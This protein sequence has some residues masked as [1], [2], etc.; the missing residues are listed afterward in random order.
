MAN[1]LSLLFTFLFFFASAHGRSLQMT[2][3][4]H[5]KLDLQ[6]DFFSDD[7]NAIKGVSLASNPNYTGK[8][9]YND[10]LGLVVIINQYPL[11][12][13]DNLDPCITP[14]WSWIL[15]TSDAR[16]RIIALELSSRDLVAP[17]PDFSIMDALQ[18][19]DLSL[20]IFS[21]PIPS[22]LGTF[23]DLQELNLEYNYFTGQVP[24]S[25]LC[26][27]NLKLSLRGN[28]A[29]DTTD[30]C[31]GSNYTPNPPTASNRNSNSNNRSVSRKKSSTPAIV[32]SIVGVFGFIGICV[33]IFAI[34]NHKARAAAAIAEAS[35]PGTDVAKG[36]TPLEEMPMNTR[37]NNMSPI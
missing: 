20:N 21:G 23:P 14:R 28:T 17:L 31:S 26:N 34:Y 1:F 25:L 15:C 32:G 5:D 9:N 35:S 18:R 27:K 30:T 29:L 2:H 33:G 7:V 12:E 37:S 6:R 19:I 22:F 36:N 11:L 24:S 3:T 4:G 8:T 13:E 10:V 16:P